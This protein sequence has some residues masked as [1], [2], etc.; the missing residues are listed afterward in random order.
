MS[1]QRSNITFWITVISFVASVLFG[2]NVLIFG[3]QSPECE[4]CLDKMLYFKHRADS[5]EAILKSK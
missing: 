5:L 1:Q 3:M 4:E 2:I